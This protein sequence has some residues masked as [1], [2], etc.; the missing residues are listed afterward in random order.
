MAVDR[1]LST[2]DGDN[3]EDGDS[4]DEDSNELDDDMISDA[5]PDDSMTLI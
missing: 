4:E 3:S 1:V 5:S 2:L